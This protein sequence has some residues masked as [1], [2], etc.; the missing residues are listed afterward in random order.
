[1]GGSFELS[2]KIVTM[3]HRESG[4]RSYRWNVYRQ[5]IDKLFSGE[6]TIDDC[7]PYGLVRKILPVSLLRLKE[8]KGE[9]MARAIPYGKQL[10]SDA[11]IAAVVEVLRHDWLTQG[12]AVTRFEQ[13]LAEYCGAKHAIAVANG[14]VAL[15]LACVAANVG[16]GDEGI[17]SPITF[18]ASANCLAYTGA[19]PVFADIQPDTW[20][21]CPREIEKRISPRT[22]V[23]IPV[24]FGGLPCEMEEIRSIADDHDLVI[25]EDACHAIGAKYKGKRM[26]GTSTADMVCFS[27]HPVKHITTGEGG[28]VVTDNDELADR[29]RTLRH[30][31]VTK[32][33]KVLEKND[34]PW[35]YEAHTLGYN[36][37][38][39]DI[40]CALGLS[41]LSQLDG[42][43]KR[44]QEIADLYL[45]EFADIS[46]VS[47][48]YVPENCRNAYHL[49]V[50]NLDTDM[51]NR[52]EIFEFLQKN[53]IAPQVH[54]V[55]VHSQ[56]IMK[57][58][59]TKFESMP[60]AEKYYSGCISL[61]MFP[62][63][64]DTEQRHVIDMFKKACAL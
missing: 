39:T 41:Q 9:S 45:S 5:K 64:R 43:L 7:V 17:T 56:P 1:M 31:G 29:L 11:D 16:H 23:L 48:Q 19:T 49:F 6:E 60:V 14:T 40:Q 26:G 30:H 46:G 62:G 13:A 24:H 52:R 53:N 58:L 61:P 44:R 2:D 37:R 55:P 38:I 12:P 18:L 34:G 54:Y 10:I 63:L 42:F 28:A 35:Y 57:K 32:D 36:A 22:K 27:F 15:H 20:N 51:Y 25:I 3:E 50:V 8:G 33:P 47:C 59:C 4:L 21:I